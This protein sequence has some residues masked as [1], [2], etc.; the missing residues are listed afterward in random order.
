M[1]TDKKIAVFVVAYNA[2]DTLVQVL[3][4]IPN[5]ILGIIEEIFVIG[6]YYFFCISIP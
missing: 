6:L 2:A 1:K 4:R 5:E 3:E